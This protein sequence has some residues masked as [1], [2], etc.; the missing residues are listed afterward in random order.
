M[1]DIK[2][3][4]W[5]S[6]KTET[7]WWQ[8]S[9]DPD[10]IKESLAN[11]ATGVTTNPCLIST[12]LKT[13]PEVW[14]KMISKIPGTFTGDEK[15]EAIMEKITVNNASILEP[16]FLETKGEQGYVC[17]QVNPLKAAYTSEMIDMAKR[18]HK[19]APN[20]A[21]K[22]P[23]TA[24]GLDAL[25]EC[26]ALGMTITATVSFTL[27]QVL[28]IAQRYKKGTE[29]ALRSGI[30]P[31]KCFAVIMIGRIDDYLRDVAVD[32][33][34]PIEED[35]I[36]KAGIAILKRAYSIFEEEKYEAV[37]LPAGMRGEYH[38]TEL[39]GAKMIFS[40]HPSIQK[41]IYN[42][43]PKEEERIEIPVERDVIDRLMKIP[44]FVRAYNPDGMKAEE[45]ITYG[46]VQK[47]LSQF[48]EAGWNQLK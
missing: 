37:L 18:L 4:R 15:A 16:V 45:F 28:H 6:E 2:Y 34:A 10:E 33:K 3:L 9:A 25:E 31:R 39:T 32:M 23:A 35:D 12:S 27:P 7:S 43:S 13:K 47:T 46:V 30:K 14:R 24:A 11:G 8:D 20:I 26:V 42:T 48:I 21:V 29:R 5:L 22:L 17:A 44:E 19:W 40:I 38:A 1:Q 41:M 36:R